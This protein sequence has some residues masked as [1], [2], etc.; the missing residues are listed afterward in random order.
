MPNLKDYLEIKQH[1]IMDNSFHFLLKPLQTLN[2]YDFQQR[3]S[4]DFKEPF[5]HV[6]STFDTTT[7]FAAPQSFISLCRPFSFQ[8]N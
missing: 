6:G 1:Y 5:A 8:I 2:P 3:K 7:P 4:N